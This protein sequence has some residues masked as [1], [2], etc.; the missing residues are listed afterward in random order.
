MSHLFIITS[1]INSFTSVIPIPERYK[2]TLKTIE[3]IRNKV[4]DS[5]VV[6]AESSPQPVNQEMLESLHSLVDYMLV[7]SQIPDIVQLGLHGQKSPAEAYSTFVTLDTIEKLNLTNV[8]RIFKLTGRGELTDEFHIEDYNSKN[9]F[10]KYVFKN[11]VD[12]WMSKDLQLVDTRIYSL[13]VSL[14]PEFKEIM[15]TIVNHSLKTGRDLEHCVFELIDKEKLIEKQ[16]MGFKCQISSTGVIQ[17][18]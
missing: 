4:S 1:A 18:D 11:R 17:F 12:S 6:L 7:N 13:C 3:S 10:A 16:V 9:L 15:K 2:Q 14:I 5:I 8:K